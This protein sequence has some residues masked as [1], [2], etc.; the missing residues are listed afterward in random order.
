MVAAQRYIAAMQAEQAR[1]NGALEGIQN[2]PRDISGPEAL[3]QGK[4]LMERISEPRKRHEAARVLMER[5]REDESL[6]QAASLTLAM[7]GDSS[8]VPQADY[9]SLLERTKRDSRPEGYCEP[10]IQVALDRLSTV[11]NRPASLLLFGGEMLD[12]LEQDSQRPMEKAYAGVRM[13]GN[14][15]ARLNPDGALLGDDRGRE[16][17]TSSLANMIDDAQSPAVAQ[18]TAQTAQSGLRE[19]G[20]MMSL[21]NTLNGAGSTGVGQSATGIRVGGVFLRSRRPR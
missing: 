15:T 6:G 4:Q 12:A 5:L 21:T 14:M 7:L 3:V 2:I 1:Q 10:A 18:I 13:L 8:E 17:L 19:L 16:F 20:Q 9:Y 11:G